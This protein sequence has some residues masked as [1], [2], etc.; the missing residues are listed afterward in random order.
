MFSNTMEDIGARIK[1]LREKKGLTQAKLAK[2]LSVNRETVNQWENGTRDLKTQYT[3]RLADFF[4]VTCDDILRGIKAENV[5]IC[6]ETGLSDK[7]IEIIKHNKHNGNH[8]LGL[9]FE[10]GFGMIVS[11][12]ASIISG[13]IQAKNE[14]ECCTE[15]QRLINSLQIN[16]ISPASGE[17]QYAMILSADGYLD[18]RLQQT[19]GELSALIKESAKSSR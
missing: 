3:I 17:G 4:G 18:I 11:A 12:W 16:R 8:T 6:A 7:A 14:E 13:Y 19:W 1:Q 9:L 15:E 10:A 2:E 5:D